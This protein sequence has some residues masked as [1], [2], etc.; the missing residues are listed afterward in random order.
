MRFCWLL[1]FV[2]AVTFLSSDFCSAKEV[3]VADQPAATEA[4]PTA[5]KDYVAA[6]DDS[7]GYK[8]VGS[9]KVDGSTVHKLELTSQTWHEIPW[10]HALYIYVPDNVQHKQMVLLFITGG[11]IGGTPSMEDMKLG[12]SL[13]KAAAMPVAYLHQV[14]NQPLLGDKVEDDLISETFLRYVDSRDPTWPLLFPMVKS[15][16]AAMT[17][18]QDF[19]KKQYDVDVEQFV[20]TGG[21]KRGWTS[22]LTA[23]ADDRVAGVAPI[24][25]DTLNLPAQMKYQL[26]TWGEYSDQ[27]ADYTSKGLVDVMQNRPDIP[28]WQWVDPYTYRSELKLPKLLINATNDPYWTVDALNQYWDGLI[29]E[30]HIRYVPN[31]GHGLD[32]GREAALMTLAAFAQHVAEGEPLPQLK[33]EHAG[34]DGELRLKISSAPEPESVRLWVARSDT[35]DFRNAKWEATEL[36]ADDGKEYVGVVERPEKGH[37][38]LFGEATYKQGALPYNLST[39]LRRE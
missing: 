7:Y 38:A 17:A 11:R 6:P 29:G 16:T 33:W 21:S 12:A 20:V 19:G 22:W 24:V 23:A 37:I 3:A 27:I 28:L 15:A 4:I 10:K 9:E 32:G 5:L 18:I 30:K 2:V 36:T 1:A 13:A 26:E 39:T 34:D 35:K 31:A 14:P 25:I 8:V